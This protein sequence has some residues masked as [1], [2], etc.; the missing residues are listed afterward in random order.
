[1]DETSIKADA[2]RAGR[3]FS[4]TRAT[5]GA[6]YL[7]S[8]ALGSPITRDASQHSAANRIVMIL[9]TR[10]LIQAVIT[11]AR[12]SAAVITLGTGADAA[13][14]ASMA[15]VG[16]LSRRWRGAAF[17]DALIAASL[18]ATGVTCARLARPAHA[19]DWGAGKSEPHALAGD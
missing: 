3:V 11:L 12:P 8:S 19:G 13:H 2:R 9:G 5:L 17:A 4:A 6:A 1:M 14:A 10:H 18:A 15:L 16:L 7:M